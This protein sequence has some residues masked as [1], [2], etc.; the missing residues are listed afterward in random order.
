M[1]SIGFKEWAI[2]CE[3]MGR[4]AQSIIVRKGGIAERRRGFSFQHR[5]FFLFPTYFHEQP[6]KVR[7]IDF[8]FSEPSVDMVDLK[9]LA[10][11]D[12][13][14]TITSWPSAQA[15]APMHILQPEVVRERFEYD[16]APGVHVAFVRTFQVMP[17]WTFP[18]EKKY[19]GCRSWV[20]LP[21]PPGDL[22]L[23]P[24]LSDAEHARRR[25]DFLEV[26]D[27]RARSPKAPRLPP[28]IAKNRMA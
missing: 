19:G 6:S 17:T 15:L 21:S 1:E 28:T 2:V 8:D 9:F 26:V 25:D 5:E 24:V 7:T 10:K 11:L 13:V 12:L 14:R 3:A 23:E 22:R 20:N 4:G 16:E 27:V 18:S